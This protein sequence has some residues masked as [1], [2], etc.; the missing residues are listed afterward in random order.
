MSTFSE[1]NKHLI[2]IITITNNISLDFYDQIESLKSKPFLMM[3]TI[4]Q[5]MMIDHP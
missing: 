3:K 2:T 4:D 5:S 1:Q